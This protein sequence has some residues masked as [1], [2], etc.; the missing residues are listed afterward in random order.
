LQSVYL[1]KPLTLIKQQHLYDLC[2]QVALL[3]TCEKHRVY[4]MKE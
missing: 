1:K 3:I 2:F 4:I